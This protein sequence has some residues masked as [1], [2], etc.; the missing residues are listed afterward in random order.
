MNE[1]PHWLTPEQQH[2]WRTFVDVHQKL[3]TTL[4]RELQDIANLS[5]ADYAV[6]VA[7]TDTP[8]GQLRFQRLRRALQWEQSRTSHHIARMAK[9]GLVTRQENPDDGR[10]VHVSITPAGRQ[11]IETAAPQHVATVRSVVI[12]P[13][14]PEELDTLTHLCQRM[15]DQLE[16]KAP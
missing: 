1:K 14:T 4:A 6:L 16:K 7:L 11:A 15:L 9:R 5:E 13:L 12:D 8:D 3:A 2:A 10:A